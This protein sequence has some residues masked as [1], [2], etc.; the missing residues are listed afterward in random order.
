MAR[1][2]WVVAAA[3]LL[4]A[5]GALCAPPKAGG[6]PASGSRALGIHAV[7]TGSPGIMGAGRFG[8]A[9]R[10]PTTS[11]GSAGF[12]SSRGL[13][14]L[15]P[16]FGGFKNTLITH[17]RFQVLNPFA[18]LTS[19]RPRSRTPFGGSGGSGSSG[20]AAPSFTD[21]GGRGTIFR[22]LGEQGAA[23]ADANIIAA[24]GLTSGSNADDALASR[25]YRNPILDYASAPTLALAGARN[26]SR[27]NNS[28]PIRP[29]NRT[30]G[31]LA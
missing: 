14:H 16:L 7:D 25:P 27:P 10:A 1:K 6:L 13:T 20:G 4:L 19:G 2:C 5:P 11:F 28:R 31:S 30:V 15:I 26:Y 22:H 12:S 9:G 18:G 17:S 23:A 29:T 24:G 3:A 21:E 8:P